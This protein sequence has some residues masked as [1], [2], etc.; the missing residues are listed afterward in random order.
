MHYIFGS[1]AVDRPEKDEAAVE[2]V[3]GELAG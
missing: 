1:H 2:A 3:C